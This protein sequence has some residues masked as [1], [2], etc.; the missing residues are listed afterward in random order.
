MKGTI[1]IGE[2]EVKANPTGAAPCGSDAIAG[3]PGDCSGAGPAD[4]L[5]Q[6]VAV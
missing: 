5:G 2:P 1:E 6:L 4:F 3:A